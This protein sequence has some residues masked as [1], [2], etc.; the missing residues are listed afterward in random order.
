[1]LIFK[2][3]SKAA[4]T[5]GSLYLAG[6]LIN[7]KLIKKQENVNW[8]QSLRFALVGAT[9]HG[10]YFFFGFKGLDRVFGTSKL[11]KTVLLKSISGQLFVFPPFVC[12][13]LGY[14]ALLDDKDPFSAISKSFLPIFLNGFYCWPMANVIT[15]KFIPVEK[16]IIWI[17]LV[18]IV[19]NSYL[20]W[21]ISKDAQVDAL[22]SKD[23][24]VDA[25]Q[26]VEQV[27]VDI[28]KQP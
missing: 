11:I 27:P 17:N 19:W 5:S 12:M 18:G 10:P 6:D 28:D 26:V 25:L 21:Q 7:Q 8:R 2:Q 3:I 16:R 24:Q 9:L 13:M 1:M 15:F 20:A 14:N 23:T 4:L 22:I